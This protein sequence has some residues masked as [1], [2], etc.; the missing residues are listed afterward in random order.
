MPEFIAFS[1]VKLDVT[2]LDGQVPDV[3]RYGIFHQQSNSPL[4]KK[5]LCSLPH[6]KPQ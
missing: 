1:K 2:I 5:W 6:G 3:L 4:H